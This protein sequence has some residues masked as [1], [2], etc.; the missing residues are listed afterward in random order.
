M[1]DAVPILINARA[2]AVDSDLVERQLLRMAGDIGLPIRIVRTTSPD[3]LK[4]T[5]AK[6]VGNKEPKVVIAG[7]DGTVA[8][9]V[10][11][12]ANTDTALGILSQGTFNNFASCLRLHHNLPAALK[13]IK[14][15]TPRSVDLGKIGDDRYFTESAG[16][17][18]FA[19]ML[20]SYGKGTNK[21]LARGLMALT[22]VA[23]SFGPH[24]VTLT[25]DGEQRVEN[26]T[27]CEICNI[28][29]I[30]QAVPIAPEADPDD[31]LLDVVI[32]HDLHR[33]EL[34]EYLR[35]LRAQVHLGLPKVKVIRA[36][37]VTIESKARLNV[38]ADDQIIGFTPQTVSIKRAALKV[39]VDEDL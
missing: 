1:T 21:N 37:E 3:D 14:D 4:S 25:L 5:I 8:L 38:H 23:L 20:A 33:R 35:A 9:A 32:L 19:D 2:G 27:L 36:K 30:A 6:L 12:L 28:Y 11:G 18:L 7:G 16:I 34:P 15:G 24:S 39:L 13:T 31:G 22:R 29:R 17:G 26:V 10:Q